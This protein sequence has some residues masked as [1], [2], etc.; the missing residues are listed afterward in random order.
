MQRSY[1][2]SLS[3]GGYSPSVHTLLFA[4]TCSVGKSQ[5]RRFLGT[6][7]DEKGLVKYLF[8]MN[9]QFFDFAWVPGQAEFVVTHGDGM[10]LFHKDAS[11]DGYGGEAIRCPTNLQYNQCSWSPTGRWLAV[12]CYNTENAS[13]PKLGLYESKKEQ[14]MLSDISIDHSAP[15]WKDDTTLY[16]TKEGDA[17]EVRLQSGVPTVVRTFPIGQGQVLFLGMIREQPLIETE[18]GV[19]LAERILAEVDQIDAR[20]ILTT[21]TAIFVSTSPTNLSVFDHEGRLT[22]KINPGKVIFF[23]P[24]GKDPSTVY[25]LANSTLL[26]IHVED[27]SVIVQEVCDLAGEEAGSHLK[28]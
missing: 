20:R 9:P 18:K 12:G 26:Y 28:Y 2:Y 3:R 22:A 10:V 27:G 24:V 11:P 13:G 6:Y 25:G 5:M 15:I 7:D 21:Q 4:T 17:M 23:G 1:S 8:P 14:F 16:T 19:A